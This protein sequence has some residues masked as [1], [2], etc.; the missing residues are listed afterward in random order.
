MRYQLQKLLIGM[1]CA[2]VALGCERGPERASPQ[3]GPLV[4]QWQYT[5]NDISEDG[6][7]RSFVIGDHTWWVP[8][9]VQFSPD[10]TVNSGY[11][12]RCNYWILNP[13]E[14][15]LDCSAGQTIITYSISGNK[16]TLDLR[17]HNTALR[18]GGPTVHF[19]RVNHI[20]NK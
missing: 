3:H 14:L 5:G 9:M 10:G 7:V 15:R 8:P 11:A 12:Q 16:L 4:G 6:F 13:T 2:L 17:G 1:V 19:E 20:E 18:G